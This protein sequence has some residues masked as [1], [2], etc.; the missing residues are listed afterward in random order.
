MNKILLFSVLLLILLPTIF[1]FIV[2]GVKKQNPKIKNNAGS[3]NS[4]NDA[5]SNG[6]YN[7]N[8]IMEYLSNEEKI[9]YGIETKEKV[10]VELVSAAEN[11]IGPLP[12][13]YLPDEYIS[14]QP[15][16]VDAD[17]DG[18]FDGDEIKLGT[19]PKNPDTDGDGI[20][21]GEEIKKGANPSL[22][23]TD[24]DG[25]SDHE[26]IFKHKTNPNNK[27]TDGDGYSDGDEVKKGYNPLVKGE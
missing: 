2:F 19:D 16:V 24:N 8:K 21:D 23:D 18:I 6:K 3:F 12:K 4:A 5:V 1:V 22:M 26:E 17:E 27:D 11:S 20:L 13:I 15:S 9:K 14:K 25:L 10:S 7:S